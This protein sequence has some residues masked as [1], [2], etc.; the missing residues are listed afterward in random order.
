MDPKSGDSTIVNSILKQLFLSKTELIRSARRAD[1]ARGRVHMQ[2]PDTPISN[3]RRFPL[4][5]EE[6]LLTSDELL[7]TS[8]G[9]VYELLLTSEGSV[10]DISL[11]AIIH[12]VSDLNV[13]RVASL[14]YDTILP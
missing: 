5:S 6:L 12:G 1:N 4:T 13:R 8:E 9:S 3:F 10:F 2:W 7:L 14:P 11:F